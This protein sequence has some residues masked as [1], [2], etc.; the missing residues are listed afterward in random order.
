MAEATKY[1]YQVRDRNG[2]LVSGKV[3]AD[4]EA[5]VASKLTKMGY[6]PLTIKVDGGTG[7]SKDLKIPGM[8]KKKV[9]LKD[10]AIFSRQFATMINSGLSM[11]RSLNILCE[12]AEN[13]NSGGS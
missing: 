6:V 12:Q 5:A 13:L 9:K 2:K 3:V 1:A 11:L 10:L 4:S 7:M 8:G